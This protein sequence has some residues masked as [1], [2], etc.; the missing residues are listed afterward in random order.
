[1]ERMSIAVLLGAAMVWLTAC[2][3]SLQTVSPAPPGGEKRLTVGTVQQEIRKG[4]PSA[5]VAEALGSPDIV[6][7]DEQGREVWIYDRVATERVQ[8]VGFAG[9]ILIGYGR[10]AAAVSQRSLTVIVKFDPDKRVRDY[11]YHAS[12]F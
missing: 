7:T 11:A 1:M 8:E 4:M 3:A 6:T 10:E 12:R 2:A 9:L 5:A